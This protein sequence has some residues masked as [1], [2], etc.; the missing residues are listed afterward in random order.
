MLFT[1]SALL[2]ASAF[3]QQSLAAQVQGNFL[4]N[5]KSIALNTDAPFYRM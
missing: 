4:V 2:V 5:N 1:S 3:V